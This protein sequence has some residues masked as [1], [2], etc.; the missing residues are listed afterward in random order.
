MKQ[1]WE[2]DVLPQL[3]ERHIRTHAPELL[4]PST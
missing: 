1:W 4:P 3:V 2:G